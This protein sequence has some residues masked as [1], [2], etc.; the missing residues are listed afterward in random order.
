[1]KQHPS[2]KLDPAKRARLFSVAAAE[3]A[4]GGF[5]NASLNRI[6][7]QV[8]MSKSSFYHYFE[9]KADLFRQVLEQS[10]APLATALETIDIDAL[11]AEN[12]WPSLEAKTGEI[13]VLLES[14][15]ELILVG[16]MT[17]RSLDNPEE[18]ALTGELM[19][20]VTAWMSRLLARGQEVGVLR[21]DLPNSLLIE[22]LMALG[23]VV[24]RWMLAR[25]DQLSETRR[26]DLE[27][28]SF[29][30]FIRILSK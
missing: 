3:F 23:M 29:N 25:W 15:P 19:E 27:Q 30:L 14:T 4:A 26:R 6:A 11:T 10:L 5:R 17:Y 20:T 1:M 28:Q 2:R 24:D 12:F 13:L 21:D 9:D 18:R 8:G 7:A 22:V 16:K